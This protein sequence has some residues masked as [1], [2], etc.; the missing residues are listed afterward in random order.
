[1]IQA[2]HW[3]KSEDIQKLVSAIK[4]HD[5]FIGSTDTVIG[6]MGNVDPFVLKKID[7]LKSRRDKPYVLLVDS[8]E[9]V[10][11]LCSIQDSR[12]RAFLKRCWPGPVT[13]ILPKSPHAPAYMGA[14]STVALRIP[15]HSGL[16]AV[17]SQLT[18]GLYSTSANI[19]GE[20]IPH[21]FEE[22]APKIQDAC[23]YYLC[24]DLPNGYVP[25][26]IIDCSKQ[27]IELVREGVYP[28]E[29]LL[30]LYH[31]NSD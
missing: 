6:L 25:S 7:N 11:A 2:L 1:M 20:P 17:L 26:T 21:G 5:L 16:Q 30:A 3:T 18:Y 4:Q 15:E 19:S 24:N 29:S 14:S 13:V 31:Q 23:Q 27:G 8:M 12:M 22:I 9:K 10:E 28:I